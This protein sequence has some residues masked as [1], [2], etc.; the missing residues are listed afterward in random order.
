MTHSPTTYFD[1]TLNVYF[2]SKDLCN[3]YK[4]RLG[5]R[6]PICYAEYAKTKEGANPKFR[7]AKELLQHVSSAHDRVLCELCLSNLKI[8]PF[9]MKCYT[10]NVGA[11]NPFL[12]SRSPLGARSSLPLRSDGPDSG[13]PRGSPPRAN[14]LRASR[15]AL[16]VLPE[17]PVRRSVA[18]EASGNEPPVLH[19]L[20]PAG[21]RRILFL[22]AIA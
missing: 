10:K 20:P 2:D 13:L 15:V 18:D 9:E 14:S 16:P 19:F 5:Y 8:F 1:K 17:V 12:F 7:N 21:A 6:C 11:R 22:A 3:A 4:E